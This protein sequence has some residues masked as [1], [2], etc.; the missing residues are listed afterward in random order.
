MIVGRKVAI[1]IGYLECLFWPRPVKC[2]GLNR[3]LDFAI[4]KFK[5]KKKNRLVPSYLYYSISEVKLD[6]NR[7]FSWQGLLSF[8]GGCVLN[9]ETSLVTLTLVGCMTIEI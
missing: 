7:M 3:F 5:S 4:V 1:V 8:F 2:G 6:L 9:C